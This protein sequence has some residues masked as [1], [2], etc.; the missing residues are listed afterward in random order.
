MKEK[1]IVLFSGG[2]DSRLVVKIMQERNFDVTA[3]YFNLPF[4][5]TGKIDQLKEFCKKEKAKFELIDCTKGKSLKA[6]LGIVKKAKHGIGTGANPCKDCKIWIFK[7]AK[8]YADQNK[9]KTIATGEVIGQRPMSQ[10][11]KALELIDKKIK[12]KLTRP[13]IEIGISGRRRDKQIELAKKFKIQYPHP[14]GGCLLCEKYLKKRFQKLLERG[15]KDEE[16]KLVGIGRQFM[17][18]KCWIILGRNEGENKILEKSKIGE[19][20]IPEFPAPSALILDKTKKDV[21]EKIL[22]IIIAYS[23]K[24]SL[25]KR[26]KFNKYK[27]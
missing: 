10:L 22:E 18:D 26:K 3:L 19:K 8:K 20:I 27:F 21:K 17:I 12:F 2:L 11:P 1:C 9:I 14:A 23:K 16:V 24:G 6:Y 15:I 4:G 5:C 25:E 7:E 13:L